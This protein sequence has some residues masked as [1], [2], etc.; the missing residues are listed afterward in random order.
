MWMVCNHG[1]AFGVLIL[2]VAGLSWASNVLCDSSN[3]GSQE[4]IEAKAVKAQAFVLVDK[5]GRTWGKLKVGEE[6]GSA[7]FS[8]GGDVKGGRANMLVT[9]KRSTI[10]L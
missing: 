10:S 2:T 3:P 1:C 6:P 5:E 9:D 8:L 7:L 4:V